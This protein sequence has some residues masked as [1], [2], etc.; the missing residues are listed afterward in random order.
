MRPGQAEDQHDGPLAL[1]VTKPLLEGKQNQKE[2]LFP[3][4]AGRD[5]VAEEISRECQH[6]DHCVSDS[7][8]ASC[9][10]E[11]FI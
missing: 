11:A 1:A 10:A 5:N 4:D 8:E 7:F 9:A 3:T 2:T 6:A